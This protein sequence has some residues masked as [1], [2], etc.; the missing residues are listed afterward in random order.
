MLEN[1]NFTAFVLLLLGEVGFFFFFTFLSICGT[2]PPPR[3]KAA[4]IRQSRRRCSPCCRSDEKSG[5]GPCPQ[6][7]CLAGAYFGWACPNKHGETLQPQLRASPWLTSPVLLLLH[8]QNE[9]EKT[10]QRERERES[11]RGRAKACKG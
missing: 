10:S 3:D 7:R 4:V 2:L 8:S 6:E 9:R 11:Q 5:G 1:E